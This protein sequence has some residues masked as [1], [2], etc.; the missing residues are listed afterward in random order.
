M[1]IIVA[2]GQRIFSR[3]RN[4]MGD[5]IQIIRRSLLSHSAI[6]SK[7]AARIVTAFLWL[8]TLRGAAAVATTPMAQDD[9]EAGPALMNSDKPIHSNEP[10]PAHETAAGNPL[11]ATP[12]EALAAT[13]DRPLFSPTR[14]PPAA[15]FTPAAAAPPRAEPIEP[16][17]PPLQL[18]GTV[19]G[20]TTAIAVFLDQTTKGT[21]RLLG[22]QSQY[23]WVLGAVHRKEVVLQKNGAVVSL[24]LSSAAAAPTAA[25]PVAAAPTQVAET[26]LE[27]RQR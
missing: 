3:D 11:W 18:I 26:R 15:V 5:F 7:S 22:G 19:A 25:A 20:D 6:G 8:A 4:V 24:P 21:I 12:I 23:G 14:R 9:A 17:R 16:E 10:A 2:C 13:R 1:A 27:R